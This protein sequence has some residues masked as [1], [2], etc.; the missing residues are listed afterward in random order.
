[1]EIPIYVLD[2]LKTLQTD[3]K[4][5]YLVG[6]CVRDLLMGKKPLDWDI[7][8]SAKPAEILALFPEAKYENDFGTVLLPIKKNNELLTVLEIT[9][10][11]SESNYQDKRHP[12]NVQF[13]TELELDL[14]RRDFTINA[15]ALNPLAE[16][17]II[18]LYGGQKDIKAKIVRAIG[19]PSDRFR[20]DALRLMRA[21][22]FCAQLGFE[23]EPKTERAIIKLAGAIKFI[24]QERIRDELI[25][26]LASDHP[27]EGID[28]LRQL[29]LLQYII[30]ELELGLKVKQDRHHI[31]PVY[32]H[33]LLSLKHC[34]SSK[35]QVR[36][37]ALLHDIGKPKTKRIIN[38][39]ATFY[40]HEYVGA[41][42]A[43]R[44]M[45]RLRFS[46]KDTDLVVNLIKN[47]MFY[48]NVGEV[49]AASVRRL[50]VKVGKDNLKD[51]MDLRIADR[52]G[53]GTPKAKPYKL[54]HLEYM[55]EKVQHDP[56]SAKMLAI[57]GDD[58]IREL[59]LEPSPK[60]GAILDIILAKVISEP[61]LNDRKKLLTLAKSL[62]KKDLA[63]LRTEA[64]ELISGKREEED[65]N[66]KAKFKV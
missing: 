47:H 42:M 2:T 4:L 9:T 25:K 15:I 6:G 5:A 54:R 17:E 61:E 63:S 66:I 38:Q 60:I 14:A 50:I 12:K 57:N 22:R 51:L 55:I 46:K 62:E 36:L 39:I 19:E 33:N 18:D 20:E 48:Y 3:N 34:P 43:E 8:T 26:I 59:K 44:I 32:Q 27:S 28:S 7:T 40:N 37:S 56:I 53:S 16:N 23:L 45:K 35:W 52:L 11:R 1:M 31:Y 24:A 41:K 64:K 30:P 58:L 10:F 65:K 21:V 49:T 29:K 13:E